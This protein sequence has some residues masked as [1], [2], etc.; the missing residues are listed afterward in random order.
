MA[1]LGSEYDVIILEDD[2]YRHPAAKQ[3]PPHQGLRHDGAHHPRQQLLEDILRKQ[4]A[5]HV[6]S[7]E[8]TAKLFDAKTATNSHTSM[9]PQVLCAEFC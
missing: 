4:V 7:D 9:L 2:F 1:E 5:G 3:R 6:L 8:I